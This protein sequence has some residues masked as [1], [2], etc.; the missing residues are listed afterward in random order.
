M[1]A[2][3]GGGAVVGVSKHSASLPILLLAL[4]LVA[5]RARADWPTLTNEWATPIKTFSDSSPAVAD[6]GTIY[7]G[8]FLGDL[9]ALNPDGSRQWVFHAGREV[10]SS[11]AIADDGTIYFGSRNRKLFAL[12][13][14]GREKWEF[15][16]GGWVDS[17]PAVAVNGTVYFGSWDKRFYAVRPDGSQAWVFPTG[18][19]IVSSAAVG[20]DGRIYFGSHDATL[21]ALTPDGN[22][23]WTHTTGG[24]I[25][26]S[27]AIDK[28]GTVYFT[29]VDGFFYALNPDGTLK[30]RLKTGGVTSSSPVIGE[31]GTLYVGVNN[32]LEALSPE[33]KLKWEQLA[34]AFDDTPLALA[35][36]F[37]TYVQGQ[38]LM[39]QDA[40]AH[41][42]WT[43]C[44]YEHEYASPGIGPK[45]D[46][47]MPGATAGAKRGFYAFPAKVPLAGSA[48]PKFRADPRNN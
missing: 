43:F 18:G 27:P 6:N 9:W 39:T 14:Q 47:Y 13:P 22:K 12:T 41:W 21:Y 42:N 31:D 33:G 11:P 46:I 29:S 35:D 45:G 32:H 24:P 1:G 26:S 40:P 16:T 10:W 36:G 7:F 25:L 15:K 30:W 5:G 28:D 8:T 3:P 44:I 17:S 2:I 4:L 37:V 19:P 48:W 20:S 23:A 34:T 38:W